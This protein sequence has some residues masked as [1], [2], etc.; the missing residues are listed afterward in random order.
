MNKNKI[1]KNIFFILQKGFSL[2]ELLVVIA[3]IGILAGLGIIGY[4]SYIEYTR[5]AVNEANAKIIADTLNAERIKPNYCNNQ[6]SSAINISARISDFFSSPNYLNCVSRI[7]TINNIVNPYTK[8]PYSSALDFNTWWYN[9]PPWPETPTPNTMQWSMYY[10]DGENIWLNSGACTDDVGG[11][12]ILSG[13]TDNNI[14]LATCKNDINEGQQ[15]FKLFA[16][17]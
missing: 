2:I 10:R 13:E 4:N 17:R 14:F 9:T 3:I 6:T 8:L 15:A 12:V 1:K 11:L 7:L 16:L 5:A